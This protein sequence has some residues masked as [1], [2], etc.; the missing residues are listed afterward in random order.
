MSHLTSEQMASYASR[1]VHG[2]DAAG[3]EAHLEGCGLCRDELIQVTGMLGHARRQRRARVAGGIGAAAAALTGVLL[4][5]PSVERDVAE[6]ETMLRD[7]GP[8]VEEGVRKFGTVAPLDGARVESLAGA[9]FLWREMAPGAYYSLTVTDERGDLVWSGSTTDTLLRLPADLEVEPGDRYFWFVE[10]L[11][12]DGTTATT[13]ASR[14]WA[15][16]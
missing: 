7:G 12:T 16:P 5:G 1:A 15:E 8:A 2:S 6:R 4:L 11:L 14:L 9:V 3:V 13:D 10:A